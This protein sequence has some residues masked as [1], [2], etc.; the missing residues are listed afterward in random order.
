MTDRGKSVATAS[1]TATS[2]FPIFG[3]VFVVLFVLKVAGLAGASWGLATLSWWWVVLPLFIPWA[4]LLV[5][6]TLG[7]IGVGI[8]LA[9]SSVL[10]KRAAKKRKAAIAKRDA[11]RQA[12]RDNRR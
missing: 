1:A 9:I 7:A 12:M 2:T 11:E 4:I 6:L 8:Y 3:L 10:D 5:I